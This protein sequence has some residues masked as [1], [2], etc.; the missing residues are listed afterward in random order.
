[1]EVDVRSEVRI[2]RPVQKSTYAAA[3]SA[4]RIRGRFLASVVSAEI[5][6]KLMNCRPKFFN[7]SSAWRSISREARRRESFMPKSGAFRQFKRK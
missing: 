7:D 5:A 1:M 3:D 6:E 4:N 2:N